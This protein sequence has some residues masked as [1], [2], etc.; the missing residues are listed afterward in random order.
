M[1]MTNEDQLQVVKRWRDAREEIQSVKR[2]IEPLQERYDLLKANFQSQMD[3]VNQLVSPAEPTKLFTLGDLA[4]ILRY[5]E[6]LQELSV[7][8]S[9]IPPVLVPNGTVNHDRV[10]K[11]RK[12]TPRIEGTVPPIVMDKW[13]LLEPYF[14][15]INERHSIYLKKQA[16]EKF[17]WTSDPILSEYSFCNVFREL[18]R[19]TIWLRQNWREPY[20]DHPNLWFAMV[21]ARHFNWPPSLQEISFPDFKT[22]DEFEEWKETAIVALEKR[23]QEG[24]KIYTGAYMIRAD[25]ALPDQSKIRYSFNLVL[26]PVWNSWKAIANDPK[27]TPFTS[28]ENATE[29]LSTFYG[30]GGFTAFETMTDLR[31]TKYL[32]NAHDIYTFANPGPGAVRGLN[33]VFGRPYKEMVNRKQAIAEMQFLLAQAPKYLAKHIPQPIEMREIENALCECDKFLRVKN[34]EGRPR[35]KFSVHGDRGYE[36]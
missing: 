35:A 29:L 33:R 34:G 30:F 8:G 20:A 14:Y 3:E 11:T 6:D 13:E 26:T 15:W 27:K 9:V 4:V 7:T 31:H 10:I 22:D 16:G 2:Q 5:G 24:H 17:P 36:V 25:A 1:L 18:D 19:V 12:R 32:C 23:Q 28:I 21:I